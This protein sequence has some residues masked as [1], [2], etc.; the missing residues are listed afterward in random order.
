[1]SKKR[2]STTVSNSSSAIDPWQRQ[3]WEGLYGQAREL[4]AKPYQAY[5]GPTV[6]GFNNDQTNAFDT[7]RNLATSNVGGA[8]LDQAV[9]GTQR[10]MNYMPQTIS[11]TSYS[12]ATFSGASAG[13][14][15]LSASRGY[16][17]ATFGGASA[18]PAATAEAAA[19]NRGNIRDVEA[20]SL[21]DQDVGAYMNPYLQNVAANAMGDLERSRLIQMVQGGNAARAAGAFGGSR[22]GVADAETNRNFFDVAGKTLTNLY[23]TGYDNALGL[24]GQDLTR[25]MQAQTSNQNV[26]MNVANTNA[27]FTQQ[28][29]LSNRDSVNSMAQFN[30]G[31][32]Q[33]TGLQNQDAVNAASRFGAESANATSVANQNALNNMAQFDAGLAQQAGL[34]NQDAVNTAA[35][36]AAD[37]SMTA[38]RDNVSNAYNA[39]NLGLTASGRM[40]DLSGQ[41]RQNA[42]GDAA[43]LEQIGNTQ[44]AQTQREYDDALARFRDQQAEPYR[45]LGLQASVLSGMPILGSTSTGTSTGTQKPSTADQFGQAVGTIGSLVSMFSDKNM[46][47]GVK[48]VSED[49][50]LRGIEKTPVKSWRYDPAKGGPNDGGARHTGPMAQDVAKNLGLGDGRT[51]PVVD[52]IGTQFAATKALAKKVKKLEAKTKKGKK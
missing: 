25:R 28:A 48:P 41:Q 22:H 18:G 36:Y 1:M 40:A 52:A 23:A 51:I 3:Q 44:Q 35:R 11:A 49:K 27:G 32:A 34:Q 10:A 4:A 50:I 7:A 37:S 33:Q 29:N 21:L 47:S 31:L 45:D 30:A 14:A 26:D 8:A 12:P 43:M 5:S 16:D 39:A 2:S 13:P 17:A 15:A 38:Q 9:A 6:A 24:A 42:Y 19:I 46:K 20:G